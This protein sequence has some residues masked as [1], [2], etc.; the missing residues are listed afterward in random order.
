MEEIEVRSFLASAV[1]LDE[2]TIPCSGLFN[3]PKESRLPIDMMVGWEPELVCILLR[4]RNYLK[5][6]GIE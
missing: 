4:R 3:P 2:Q 5:V 6:L 1:N